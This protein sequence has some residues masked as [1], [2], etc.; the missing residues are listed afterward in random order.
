MTAKDL[1]QSSEQALEPAMAA[2]SASTMGTVTAATKEAMMVA[3]TE[4]ASEPD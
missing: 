2:G 3:A 1:D 4:A